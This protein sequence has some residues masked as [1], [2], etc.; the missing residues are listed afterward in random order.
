MAAL[1]GMVRGSSL[2]SRT[3]VVIVA[4]RG[5]WEQIPLREAPGPWGG[6]SH[7]SPPGDTGAGGL[8]VGWAAEILGA[9]E[10]EPRDQSICRVSLHARDSQPVPRGYEQRGPD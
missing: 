7:G 1:E 2:D 10:G 5:S 8:H 4:V 6:P 3:A 9:S